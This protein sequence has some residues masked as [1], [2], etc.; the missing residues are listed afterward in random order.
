M[1]KGLDWLMRLRNCRKGGLQ[2][3]TPGRIS[4]GYLPGRLKAEAI[5]YTLPIYSET[6]V[7]MI[8]AAEFHNIT[9]GTCTSLLN[10][11]KPRNGGS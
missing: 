1:D 9:A 3:L 7:N 6:H 8:Y 5:E 4:S 2:K 11:T 10:L